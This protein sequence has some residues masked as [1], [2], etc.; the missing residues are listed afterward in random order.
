MGSNKIIFENRNLFSRLL[1]E[2]GRDWSSYL[3]L[4]AMFLFFTFNFGGGKNKLIFIGLLMSIV[5]ISASIEL[6]W[7]SIKSIEFN[8]SKKGQII[9]KFQKG[10]KPYN[11]TFSIE[12]FKIDKSNFYSVINGNTTSYSFYNKEVKIVCI[13]IRNR[14]KKSNIEFESALKIVE[15][16]IKMNKEMNYN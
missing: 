9:I 6:I 13:E 2:I 1:N 7:N 4:I 11:V 14:N 3:F 10:F 16:F 15:D 8:D 12:N 5:Q